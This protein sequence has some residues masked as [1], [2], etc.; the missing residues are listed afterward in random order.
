[1]GKKSELDK[2]YKQL[3]KEKFGE[4]LS[5][6]HDLHCAIAHMA[7]VCKEEKNKGS[8]QIPLTPHPEKSFK[9]QVYQHKV[10][11]EKILSVEVIDAQTNSTH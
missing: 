7:F 11:K 2:A 6:L 9:F 5:N 4:M 10:T 8:L 3:T 1:M